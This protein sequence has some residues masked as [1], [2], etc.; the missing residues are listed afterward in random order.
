[1][2]H[3]A[4]LGSIG[5]SLFNNLFDVLLQTRVWIEYGNASIPPLPFWI[6]NSLNVYELKQDVLKQREKPNESKN[7]EAY[8]V[9]AYFRGRTINNDVLI[10]GI[11]TT[12]SESLKTQWKL[13]CHSGNYFFHSN[14]RIYR[15]NYPKIPLICNYAFQKIALK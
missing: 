1:M 11:D 14:L 7:V 3:K 6:H 12:I 9:T 2:P 8:D 13:F 5:C 10:S 15:E 4:N